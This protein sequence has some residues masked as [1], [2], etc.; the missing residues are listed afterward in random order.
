M[1]LAGIFFSEISVDKKLYVTSSDV[2]DMF[3]LQFTSFFAV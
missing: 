3:W 1:N 2:A